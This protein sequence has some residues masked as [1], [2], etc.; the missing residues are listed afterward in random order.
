MAKIARRRKPATRGRAGIEVTAWQDDPMSGLPPIARPEPAIS[1]GPLAIKIVGRAPAAKR[2]PQG[3]SAFRYWT[4]ADALDRVTSFWRQILPP[5]TTWQPGAP[6]RVQ[7]DV[8]D[9]LNAYY[10]RK[11]LSFFHHQA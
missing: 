11:G 4:A 1:G 3:T 9:Y 7:L 10:D 5:K 2:Y 8:T 6:L